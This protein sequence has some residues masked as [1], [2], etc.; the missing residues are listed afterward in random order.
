MRSLLISIVT[1]LTIGN[2]YS[3]TNNSK[4]E[5]DTVYSYSDVDN[6]PIPVNGMESLYKKWSA[7]VKYPAEARRKGTQ[8]KVFVSFTIDETGNLID[9]K[10]EQGLGHGCDE[11]TVEA[12]KKADIKWTPGTKD[13]EK[14]KVRMF[15]P[16]T[17]KLG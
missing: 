3:F 4:H 13:G 1:I 6:K 15:L 12:L 5:I 7:V 2:S 10:V 14:V 8:G 9:I 17:F 16:F 11:A